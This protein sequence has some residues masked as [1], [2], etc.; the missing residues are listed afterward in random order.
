MRI[1]NLK[2]LERNTE[3]RLRKIQEKYYLYDRFSCFELNFTGA[4]IINAIGRDLT[5]EELVLKL[6]EKFQFHDVDTIK[7]D[8]TSY[9]DFLVEQ[10]LVTIRE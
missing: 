9:I 6:A 3:T 4:T 2:Q 7:E 10:G 8:V 1:L 5:I